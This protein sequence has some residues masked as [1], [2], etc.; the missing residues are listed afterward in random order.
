MFGALFHS[1]EDTAT[2]ATL[3][4]V[5]DSF[6]FVDSRPTLQHLFAEYWYKMQGGGA[7]LVQLKVDLHQLALCPVVEQLSMA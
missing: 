6:L 4:F 2:L 1:C 5:G 3:P 7:F